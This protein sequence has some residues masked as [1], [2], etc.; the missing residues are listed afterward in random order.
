MAAGA[1]GLAEE[2]RFTGGSAAGI[3]RGLLRRK[4]RR[5]E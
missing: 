1:T 3:G 2:Q 5:A 4:R